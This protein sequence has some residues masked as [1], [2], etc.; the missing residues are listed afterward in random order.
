M[1]LSTIQIVNS[2]SE[3]TPS[4]YLTSAYGAT[5]ENIE[6]RGVTL[7]V[8][9]AQELPRQ[10]HGPYVESVK[11]NVDDTPYAPIHVHFDSMA[12]KIH[13]HVRRGGRALVHC[14][15]GVSRSTTILLAY[16]MK[17]RSMTLKVHSKYTTR[18]HLSK[19]QLLNR[20]LW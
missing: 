20:A 16:L 19:K 9:C 5:R 17:H 13:E 12:D 4:L 8:N 1:K 15:V 6:R 11:L 7:V 3:I 2:V 10:D 14:L 18:S